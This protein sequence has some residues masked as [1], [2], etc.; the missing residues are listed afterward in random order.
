MQNERPMQDT[1]EM[2][3]RG[4]RIGVAVAAELVLGAWLAVLAWALPPNPATSV[5]AAATATTRFTVGRPN[6]PPTRVSR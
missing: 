3:C 2:T 1:L 6:T 5:V 4:R